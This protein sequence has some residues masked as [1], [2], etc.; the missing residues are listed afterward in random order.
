MKTSTSL[1]PVVLALV[2]LGFSQQPA[3][4]DLSET[5]GLLDWATDGAELQPLEKDY[6]VKWGGW[7][8][9]GV[10]AN[11]GSSKW[12]GPVTF[13]DRSG[14]LQMNQFYL[15]VERA[16]AAEGDD[17]DVGGRFDFM[18]GTDAFYTQAYGAPQGNWDLNLVNRNFPS[19]GGQGYGLYRMALPQAY[20]SVFM[21]FG[22]GIT[23]KIGH[24]YTPIGNEVVTAP[25]NFFY[26]HAYTMQFGEPFT[27]TGALFSYPFDQNWTAIG[28]VVTGAVTGGWDGGF[29]QGL[30]NWDGLGGI[31]WTSDDKGTSLF[32]SG[33]TGPTSEQNSANWSLY[34]LVLKHD[35]IDGLHLTMQHDHGYA[36][37]VNGLQ[38]QNDEWYGL[39][40]YLVYDIQD[41]LGIGIRGEWFRDDGALA[42]MVGPDGS[43]SN[44]GFGRVFSPA[45]VGSASPAASWYGITLGL[46]Y[47]PV[48]WA[49]VRPNLR[50]DFVD[51]PGDYKPFNNQGYDQ[52]YAGTRTSQFLISTD[53]VFTF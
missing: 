7:L 46:N 52:G 37:N 41:N 51:G 32:A 19:P 49:I 26:S 38:G 43:I 10:S 39:N 14:E 25:D 44:N 35:I 11:M 47:K 21:P 45:R 28:G 27:H 9:T 24:F 20:A 5:T 17:W 23:A 1:R 6:G 15:Y 36:N 48:K 29:N 12:N 3:A 30:G 18:Y 2:A 8:D 31:T 42:T 34:S 13:S 53:V 40:N 33:T 50:Y 22:N 16:V 4:K